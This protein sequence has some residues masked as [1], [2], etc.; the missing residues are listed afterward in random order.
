MKKIFAII[1]MALVLVGSSQSAMTIEA[2][3]QAATDG[4]EVWYAPLSIYEYL[5]NER[6][7]LPGAPF[8][9]TTNVPHGT[10][11]QLTNVKSPPDFADEW[12]ISV[13]GQGLALSRL[14]VSLSALKTAL[15]NALL[16]KAAH[17]AVIAAA[18]TAY[19]NSVDL[20][21]VPILTVSTDTLDFGILE[22]ELSFNISNTGGGTLTW[23]ITTSIPAKISVLPVS[24]IGAA[25]VAVT[26]N[27][28]GIAAGTYY[29]TV[30]IS[31]D[32][33][34]ETITL[35]VVVE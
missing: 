27:R 26:V 12:I 20:I 21:G 34:N 14:F 35:T 33:G 22:T 18:D 29:P 32:G 3:T 30:S 8:T 6:A 16:A 23:S 2:V 1:I 4:D 25:T 9:N 5:A 17:A 15:K 31:S 28:A 24:G 10:V 7:V 19:A 11:D 13:N